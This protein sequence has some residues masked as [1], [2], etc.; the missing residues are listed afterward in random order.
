[1]LLG[2]HDPVMPHP[3][4]LF[5]LRLRTARLELRLP[6]DTDLVHLVEI[7]RVGIHHPSV[8]PFLVAWTDLPSPEFERSALQFMWGLRAS[9][10]SEHWRLALP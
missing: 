9:W 2:C 1:M 7:A 3:W 4:P 10:S 6:T 8:M 5:D